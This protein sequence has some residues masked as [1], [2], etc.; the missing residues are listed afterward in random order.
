[1]AELGA[2]GSGNKMRVYC[3]VLGVALAQLVVWYRFAEV[4]SDTQYDM[5]YSGNHGQL[6]ANAPVFAPHGLYFD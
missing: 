3:A 6:G 2:R 5:S 4:I 1:M